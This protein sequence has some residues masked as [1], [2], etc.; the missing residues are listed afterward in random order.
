MRKEIADSIQSIHTE[1]D[2]CA[3][4]LIDS[5]VFGYKI[6]LGI[7]Y[8][9]PENSSYSSIELFEGIE[10]EPVL[11]YNEDARVCIM[12]D[13]NARTG[14]Q[15]DILSFDSNIIDLSTDFIQRCHQ[16]GTKLPIF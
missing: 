7:V 6:I 10:S 9:P 12:G 16:P 2:Y 14:T 13:F 3:C 15:S 11:M 5:K 8:I 4:F 1:Y